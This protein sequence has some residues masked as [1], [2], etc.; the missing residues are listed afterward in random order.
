MCIAVAVILLSLAFGVHRSVAAE[1][2][3]V[4]TMFEKGT[5]GS[6]YGI[7]PDL[8][9]RQEDAAYLTRLAERYDGLER[10]TAAVTA[11]V[12]ELSDARTAGE[13]FD[14]NQKLEAAVTSLELAMKNAP[15]SES[16]SRFLAEAKAD[17]DSRHRTV[18]REAAKYNEQ[19][20]KFEETVLHGLPV[21]L[22]G[23]VFGLPT[24][25]AFE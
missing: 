2:K 6:G 24:V 11:A 20:A 23:W 21:R 3:K 1:A 22:F 18:T 14:A 8:R 25:E 7:A 12:Q 4:N 19:V 17:F 15:L 9:D 5:D 13:K 10:E 16:D